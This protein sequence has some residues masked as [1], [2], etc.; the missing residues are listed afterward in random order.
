MIKENPKIVY[1]IT[2]QSL[3]NASNNEA[4]ANNKS[5]YIENDAVAT[6]GS[7]LSDTVVVSLDQGSPGL[8]PDG[9][10]EK[11][12]NEHPKDWIYQEITSPSLS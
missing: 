2:F 4:Y 10:Q 12:C 9:F 11:E 8:R 3:Q 5:D 7:T 6:I 1:F